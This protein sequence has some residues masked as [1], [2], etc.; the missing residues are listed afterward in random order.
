MTTWTDQSGAAIPDAWAA[1][2]SVIVGDIHA[3]TSKPTPVDADE[4]PILD[5]T[6]VFSLKKLT[7]VNLKA[8]LLTYFSALTSTW[9]ISTTGNATTA[10]TATTATNIAAG[11]VGVLPY[12]S[13]ASTTLFLA[14][15]V[16][17]TPQ[18]LTSTGTGAV[19]QAPILTGSTGTGSVVLTNNSVLVAPDLGTPA[20][21]ILTNCTGTAAGLSIG[22]NAATATTASITTNATNAQ[23]PAI[24]N[25]GATVAANAL[26][27]NLAATS[28]DF[29]SPTLSS[30]TINTR[31][32]SA[33]SLV[34]PSTATLGTVNAQ[35]ARL[36]LIA[37][38]NS[39]TVELAVVN[40]SGGNNLDETTLISTT[41]IS[42]AAT[43]NNVIY[44]TTG[45][46]NIPFR[47][48]G[49]IDITE[50][51]AGTWATAP[52]TIQG[53][54]GQASTRIIG[55]Q[56]SMVRLNTANG[57]GS[58]STKI[59]RFTNIV[60][61]QGADITYADSATLGGSFTINTAGVYSVSYNDQF[62]AA[63]FIGIS[64]NTTQPT[65]NINLLAATEIFSGTVTSGANFASVAAASFY[66]AAGSIIRAHTDGTA[67]GTTTTF[68]QFTITKLSQ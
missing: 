50:A 54:G 40:L 57:Y 32:F 37:I 59:R 22:G 23:N 42:A 17:A 2:V 61:T 29:R 9:A 66:L 52:T 14:G 15:N 33:L 20:A 49:F 18:F 63:S 39:G 24:R 36:V 47:V 1:P 8:T 25:T 6:T 26:T 21:G 34:V 60:T 65:V 55:F 43:A 27:L 4:I 58:T 12:Q 5:S 3:A 44:S 13:A 38:D 30:G 53:A 48:V 51:T 16:S 35:A 62:T 11:T 10:T 68:C 45:R 19:A 64:L 56:N 46:T 67:T 31:A 7:W 28:I 41:A